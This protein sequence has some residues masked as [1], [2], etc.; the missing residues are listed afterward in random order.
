MLKSMIIAFSTYSKIPMPQVEWDK[1][2]MHYSLCFFPFVGLAIGVIFVFGYEILRWIGFGK[3]AISAILTVLPVLLNGGIHMDGFLD[4]IDAKSSYQPKE[5]KLRILKDPHMGAFAAIYGCVYLLLSFGLVS[6]IN[7][8]TI[9]LVAAGFIYSRILSGWSIKTFLK[10]KHDGMAATTSDAASKN[11]KWILIIEGICT[12]IGM[13]AFDFVR[14]G[15]CILVGLGC[16]FYYRKMA[17]KVFGGITGDLAGYF[18]QLCEIFILA[19]L[20]VAK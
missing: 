5:E 1:K 15:L 19:I 11:V 17:Y 8:H 7:Q 18:L 14:G 3:I 4:T 6:E 9:F 12:A 2:S 20:A 10:A 16:L 13:L